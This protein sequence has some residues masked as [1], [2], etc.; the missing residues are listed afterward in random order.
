MQFA[1][2]RRIFS[3]FCLQNLTEKD[4]N[5]YSFLRIVDSFL[6]L[7]VWLE[8]LK[9]R[10]W[11][12]VHLFLIGSVVSALNVTSGG[13]FSKEFAWTKLSYFPLFFFSMFMPDLLLLERVFTR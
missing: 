6:L 4:I 1:R 8:P 2:H 12:D 13:A 9:E 10:K 3:Y 11:V 7:S 5:A